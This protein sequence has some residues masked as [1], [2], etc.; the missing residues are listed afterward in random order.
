MNR[1]VVGSAPCTSVYVSTGASVIAVKS[2]MP[3]EA[4]IVSANC[5][6]SNPVVPGRNATGMKTDISTSD[7]AT[8]APPISRMARAVASNGLVLSSTMWR[9]MFSSTTMASSTT[10]PVASVRPKS[11][12]V[13]IEKP[14]QLH[15]RERSD[16]RH[17]DRDRR[18][19]RAVPVLQED[20]DDE[21][22]QQDRDQQRDDDLFDRGPH[23]V[24][25]VEGD[26]V[27]DAGRHVL[28]DP[29]HRRANVLRDLQR[30]G[31]RLALDR[32]HDRRLAVVAR[33]RHV[34]LRA[35]LDLGQVTDVAGSRRWAAPRRRSA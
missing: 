3:I 6:N 29:R 14:E 13:L 2:E 11:V 16:Q 19:E 24:G 34:V 25:R 15:R 7:V 20:E 33:R 28:R 9:T 26:L 21:D 8:T 18:D 12:S 1:L 10:R 31:R 35:E 23:E 22:D 32:E 30:I 17:R 5:W 4:A 27:G